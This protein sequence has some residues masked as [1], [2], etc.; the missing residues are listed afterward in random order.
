MTMCLN[1]TA[2]LGISFQ[3]SLSLVLGIFRKVCQFCKAPFFVILSISGGV[4]VMCYFYKVPLF[5]NGKKRVPFLLGVSGGCQTVI[6]ILSV[7]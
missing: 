4:F 7:L 3:K 2:N 6:T 5:S 1:H